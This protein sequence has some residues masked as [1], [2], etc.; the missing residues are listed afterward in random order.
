MSL[1]RRTS[2]AIALMGG[3]LLAAG[4]AVATDFDKSFLDDYSK[5]QPRTAG[6]EEGRRPQRCETPERGVGQWFRHLPGEV[7]QESQFPF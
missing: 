6:G 1:H 5:L 7:I 3:S 4:A 2:F